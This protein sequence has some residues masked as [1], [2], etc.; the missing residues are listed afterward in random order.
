V[1]RRRVI[2]PCG[3]TCCNNPSACARSNDSGARTYG[4][5]TCACTSGDD[6]C[7]CTSHGYPFAFFDADGDFGVHT[8]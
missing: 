5:Y 3:G 4:V 8:N 7:P 6:A 1:R 2:E